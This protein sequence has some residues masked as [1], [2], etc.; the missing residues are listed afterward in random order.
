MHT[1]KII[2]PFNPNYASILIDG[3]PLEGV[4]RVGLSLRAG[5]P[6]VLLLAVHGHVEV[7]GEFSEDAI[8]SVRQETNK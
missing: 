8:L 4:T 2:A 1:F 3:K 7:E 5:C 6:T